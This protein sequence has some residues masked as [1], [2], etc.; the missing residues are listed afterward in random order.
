[1]S[2]DN[3]NLV[4]LAQL[5]A[6]RES[7]LKA[8]QDLNMVEGEAFCLNCQAKWH[9]RAPS[10]TEYMQC[11]ECHL[12][13]GKFFLPFMKT[14]KRHWVCD[15]GNSLFSVTVDSIYCPNCGKDQEFYP[16]AG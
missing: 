7:K 2:S 11:P 5:R 4:S 10:G 12:V 3:S 6:S 9:A 15:C 1:M 14:D 8:L 16:G 13:K